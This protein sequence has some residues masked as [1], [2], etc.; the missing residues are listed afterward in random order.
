MKTDPAK[1]HTIQKS[2]SLL[3][4]FIGI[5]LA[6]YMVIVESEPG[7]LP[8]LLIVAGAGWFFIARSNSRSQKT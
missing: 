6:T 4:T 5:V 3:L 2:L 8:L 1:R 7:A